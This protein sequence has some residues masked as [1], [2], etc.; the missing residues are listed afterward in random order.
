MKD[1]KRMGRAGKGPK[2]DDPRGA[3]RTR[4][5][6]CQEAVGDQRHTEDMVKSAKGCRD[7]N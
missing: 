5:M 1:G 2:K 3:G 6:N 4:R 7:F